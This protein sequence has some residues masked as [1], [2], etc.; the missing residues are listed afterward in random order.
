[1][2]LQRVRHDWATELIWVSGNPF[3]L[4]L[5]RNTE[6]YWLTVLL[7]VPSLSHPVYI[8]LLRSSSHVFAFVFQSLS[9]VQIFANPWTAAC[10]ASLSFTVSWS[11]LKFMSIESV[12]LSNHLVLCHPLLLLP[13]TFPSIR[14]FSNELALHIR[15][16]KYWSFSFS[17]SI[18]P[19]SE[20]SGLISFGL[21]GLISLQSKGLSR[22]FSNTTNQSTFLFNTSTSN[23]R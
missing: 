12:M 15:W 2:G 21:T 23:R 14:V 20:Y 9:H 18:T 5:D 10:Q 6:I 16:P 17:I 22:V 7:F 8:L 1:M 13:S 3:F 11:L 19:S 4:W